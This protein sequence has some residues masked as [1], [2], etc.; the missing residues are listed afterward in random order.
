MAALFTGLLILAIII[1]LAACK[2]EKNNK[3]IQQ[4]IDNGDIE[5]FKGKIVK[6]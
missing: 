3:K 5:P 1:Y 4:H 6:F 2:N